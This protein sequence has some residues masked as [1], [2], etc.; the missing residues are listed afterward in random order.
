M[1]RRL[2]ILF[3]L[4]LLGTP[5]ALAQ[6]EQKLSHVIPML[7]GSQGLFLAEPIGT[8]S[9]EAHFIGSS[10]LGFSLF[11]QSLISQLTALPLPSPG[12]GISF[13][14]DP[15]LGTLTRSTESF[16][17]VL[18]ERAHTIGRRRFTFG[19]S[20]QHFGFDQIEGIDLSAVPSV[21]TH[22]RPTVPGREFDFENDVITTTSNIDLNVDEVTTFATFGLTDRIDL[23]VA[24]PIVRTNLRVSSQAF[25]Q[26]LG[27]PDEPL[28]HRF[29]GGADQITQRQTGSASGVG[30]I[31]LRAKGNAMQWENA[32]LAFAMDVRLP[33][34][35]E[36]NLLGSGAFGLKPF[37]IMSF[38]YGRF[39]PHVNIG[40]QWNGDSVLGGNP[41]D[42]MKGDLPDQF[43]YV[44]GV[45]VRLHP[46][47][48]AAFDVLGQR[49]IDTQRLELQTFTF[50]DF[51]APDVRYFHGSLNQVNG[52]ASVKLNPGS[53]LLID[54]G[55]IFRMNESGLRDN[56]TPLVG[57]SYTF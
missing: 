4:C 56:V 26:R 28:I 5:S 3:V 50:N 49:I 19:V 7:Y 12:S 39:S 8:P 32:G 6:S 14:L 47:I 24:V 46:R 25:V 37:A 9:H 18:S 36:E 54:F 16:G 21:L 30:D 10:S 53:Q 15:N 33:T 38:S 31:V 27:T 41:L 43:L 34:G 11:N 48:T 40:Y 1:S 23:S 52:A 13:S 51:T 20:F 22:V 57:V 45:D 17:S 29:P 35:D 44:G 42:G 2:T 55:L